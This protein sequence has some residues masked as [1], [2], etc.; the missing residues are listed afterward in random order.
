MAA[1]RRKALYALVVTASVLGAAEWAARQSSAEMPQWSARDTPSV[2]MTGHPTRLW[3]LAAGE[4]KNVDTVAPIDAIGLR[5]PVPAEPRADGAQRI[6]ILGDSSFFGF[7]VAD[8][9]TMAA[10]LSRRLDG[11]EVINGAVP[12]YSTE[13]SRR[14]MADVGWDLDPTLLVVANFWSDTNFEPF[15]DRDLLATADLSQS[16]LGSRIALMRWMATALAAINP[17]A[18]G[19]IVTWPRGQPLPN[20]TERRVPVDD[21]AAN[22]DGLIRDARERGIGVV[23]FTP[24]SPVEIEATVRPPHQ[25][26]P[27]RAAQRAVAAAHG[28]PHIDAT[29]PFGDAVAHD[30][31]GGLE[32]WFLDDLHPTAAGQRLMARLVARVLK[33]RNWPDDPLVGV[34]DPAID[35]NAI[36]DTTPASRA[37]RPLGDRSPISNLF[38]GPATAERSPPPQTAPPERTAPAPVVLRLQGGTPPYAVTVQSDGVTVASARVSEPRE[39][40]LDAPRTPLVVTATDADG[41]RRT[42]ELSADERSLNVSF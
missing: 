12:G 17:A 7:G 37:G 28:L 39:L 33:A 18:S 38:S 9:Q 21:Y 42:Q 13:Q 23:L 5:S 30:S 40:S 6:M 4:R 35:D 20:A 27:Y 10:H 31:S 36:V 2:V 3:G 29:G 11:V 16:R 15:H 14:L 26:D 34:A 8:D 24:P 22:L 25:W 41:V 32:R 1:V 19:Q